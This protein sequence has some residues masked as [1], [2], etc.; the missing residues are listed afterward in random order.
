MKQNY[1]TM[2]KLK[3]LDDNNGKHVSLLIL[4]ISFLTLF[5]CI[6]VVE[7][8][9]REC[10][11]SRSWFLLEMFHV[12]YWELSKIS[13]WCPKLSTI[14][15]NFELISLYWAQYLNTFWFLIDKFLSLLGSALVPKV[16][17]ATTPMFNIQDWIWD[18]VKIMKLSR[19]LQ[20]N[21]IMF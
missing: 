19:Y 18:E 5:G 6:G 20:L 13:C 9:S 3:K 7:A 4:K 16:P 2:T 12:Q 14:H 21:W 11:F 8:F 1:V 15:L 10:T 17:I